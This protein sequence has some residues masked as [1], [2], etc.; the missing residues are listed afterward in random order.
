LRDFSG[1]RAPVPARPVE[2]TIVLA[3]TV[4]P[5]RN[6]GR[7]DFQYGE[8]LRDDFESGNSEPW[9]ADAHVDVAVLVEIARRGDT[10]LVG[11]SADE[12]LDR[13][14]REDLV[15]AMAAALAGLRLDMHGDTR[16]VLLTLA[17]IWCTLATG[18]ILSKDAAASWALAR[19]PEEHR[20]VLVRARAIYL[21]EEGEVWDD[22]AVRVEPH[23]EHVIGEIERERGGAS[24]SRPSQRSR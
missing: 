2:L 4:R 17:R 8:W 10:P 1:R 13:V 12:L 3:P 23:V 20:A 18:E 22:I 6:P 14:P 5:W 15:A 7:L 19:L 24:R 16:N 21:D 9:A 11:P